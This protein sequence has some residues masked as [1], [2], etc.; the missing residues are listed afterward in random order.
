MPYMSE[1]EGYIIFQYS[2]YHDARYVWYV[3]IVPLL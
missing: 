2:L 1:L 3:P